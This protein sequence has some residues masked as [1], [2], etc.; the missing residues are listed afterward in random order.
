MSFAS[1]DARSRDMRA[2]VIAA[3]AC[4]AFA[5]GCRRAAPPADLDEVIEAAR[6][7]Q[8]EQGP[9]AA[10]PLLERAVAQARAA[11]SRRHEGLALGHLGT[12]FKNLADYTRA[13]ESHGRALAIK[14]ELGDG[15]EQAK[16]LNNIGLVEEARGNCA[17]ALELYSQSLAIF[18]RHDQPRFAASV[19]NN[20]ALCFDALGQFGQSMATYE[21][22]FALHRAEG[23]DVGE[24][25]TLGNIGGVH[26]L[27]GRYA[28]AAT[29]YEA[30]LAISTRLDAAQSLTLDLI[31]LGSVRT[32]TGDLRAAREHLERAQAI[33]RKAGLARED[34]DAARALARLAELGGRYDEARTALT[35]AAAIYQRAGLGRESVDAAHALGQLDLAT[36]DLGGAAAHFQRASETAA[37]LRY[38]T[39][40]TASLL[41]LGALEVRRRNLD[42]AARHAAAASDEGRSRKD[43]G[44]LSAASLLLARIHL[45]AR[46]PDL[47]R[48]AADEAVATARDA[49][50]TLDEA[51]ARLAVGDAARAAG[52]PGDALPQ[53]ESAS[54][55][56]GVAEVPDLIW[57]LQFGRGRALEAMGRT[58]D[59]LREYVAAVEL[60][61]RTRHLLAGDRARTGY[62]DDKR[63][64]YAA[65]VRLLLRLKRPAEAFQ[66]A[67]RLRAEGYLELVARSASLSSAGPDAIPADLL[68]RI[69]QLQQSIERELRQ[70]GELR[71]GAALTTYRDELRLAEA[72]WA[73]AVGMLRRGAPGAGTRWLS[74]MTLPDVAAIQRQ[75]G[76]ADALVQYVV[77][78]DETV[79]FVLRRHRIDATI[80]PV[81]ADRLRT[82]VELLRGLL[83]RHD[84]T[85]WQGPAERLDTEL[86]DPLRRNGWLRGVERLFLVPHAELNYVPF[87]VLRRATADGPRL[88]VEDA[89]IV[90]L[91]AATALVQ[92]RRPPLPRGALLAL[93]PERPR[94]PFA[95]R[96]VEALGALY[97]PSR[98]QVLLGAAAT[99]ARFKREVGNYRVIHLATHGFFNR[100]NPLFSGVDLEAAPG[101]DGRLQVFEI[102]GLSLG[103]ELVTLSAC[104]TALGAGE[105]TD[106]PAGEEL[107]GLTRAFLSAGSRHVLATLWEINDEATAPLMEEFYRAARRQPAADALAAVMRRRLAAGGRQAHPYYWA[108]FVLVGAAR[109]TETT[110]PGP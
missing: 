6:T 97:S 95:R 5:A 10:L 93:A 60:V 63:E 56:P 82:R 68:A 44:S 83:A 100:I 9:Q 106:L 64:L 25:E 109:E 70:P 77:D 40:R 88:L 54:R 12:A 94:L 71:R 73:E 108:P 31:N 104:D 8:R 55:L 105:L 22:A 52:R 74:A 11:G 29:R 37:R 21:R 72:D 96:E 84:S 90:V 66:V 2:V 58:D 30:S 26:L 107:V 67:E 46:R 79:A 53:Y 38:A 4:V 69:R 28:D 98:R 7:V 59:A 3:I 75:L 48:A 103:A 14:R 49:G 47:A 65:L 91:P 18:T 57:R 23:N 42:A 16:T 27:L 15:I 43:L 20:Q 87:A 45:E 33:A 35:E 19:L 99:E 76:Q 86:L 110:R 85:E 92:G 13:M 1:G 101:E 81:G 34:A 62:L 36:G 17:A 51:D 39:G 80:L 50:A 89:S 32:A 78:A 102:L 41:A 24:S 61:E